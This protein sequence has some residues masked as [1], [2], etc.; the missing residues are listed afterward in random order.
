MIELADGESFV[1]EPGELELARR[2]A[3]ELIDDCGGDCVQALDRVEARLTRLKAAHSS[4]VPL[5]AGGRMPRD[6]YA[7][8]IAFTR[9]VGLLIVEASE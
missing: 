2:E 8:P 3:R 7:R 6:G 4:G 5:L 9:V 1:F